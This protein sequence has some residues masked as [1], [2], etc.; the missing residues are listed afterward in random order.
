[1]CNQPRTIDMTAR[2]GQFMEAAPDHVIDEVL[3]KLQT[4]FDVA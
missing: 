4:I 3:A 1:M 2:Q